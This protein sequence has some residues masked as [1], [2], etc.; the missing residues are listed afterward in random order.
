MAKATKHP[1]HW[2][3]Y[4]D[5]LDRLERVIDT[6]DPRLDPLVRAKLTE[7]RASIYAA[8][9]L[10]AR[11]E[12]LS[13]TANDLQSGFLRLSLERQRAKLRGGSSTRAA[14]HPLADAGANP[15]P[16]STPNN[17]QSR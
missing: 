12:H 1:F 11:I 4:N 15:A 9:E 8:W 6:E 2:D 16:R 17:G 7:A 3:V 13:P 5:L 10:Q 14:G